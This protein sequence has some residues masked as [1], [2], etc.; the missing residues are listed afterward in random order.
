MD[1][2]AIQTLPSH[3]KLFCQR[4]SRNQARFAARKARHFLVHRPHK[5]NNYSQGTVD[6]AAL[7][8]GVIALPNL[9]LAYQPLEWPKNRQDLARPGAVDKF[10]EYVETSLDV[11][12]Q[13]DGNHLHGNIPDMMWN[14]VRDIVNS[15]MGARTMPVKMKPKD[16]GQRLLWQILW[17]VSAEMHVGFP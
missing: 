15:S 16:V 14:L 6:L 5:E 10:E 7:K 9:L 12:K 17:F 13:E 1:S 2:P 11:L 8:P 4:C 3:Y